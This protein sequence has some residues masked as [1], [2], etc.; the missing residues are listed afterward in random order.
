M[1]ERQTA[2]REA[3]EEASKSRGEPGQ[4]VNQGNS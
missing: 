4:G 1:E 3:T 2:Q